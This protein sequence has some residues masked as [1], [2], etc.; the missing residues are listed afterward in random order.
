MAGM[1]WRVETGVSPEAAY[2]Y[3]ADVSHHPDWAMDPMTVDVLEDGKRYRCAAPFFGRP[4]PSTVTVT[5]SQR[6]SR[7]AF[8][9]EDRQGISHHEFRFTPTAGGTL[10]TREMTGV[11]QP[12]YGPILAMLFRG[13]IDKNFNGA[14]AKL[15]QN[16]ESKTAA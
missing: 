3:V 12:W 8:D 15:K 4:N 6:P 16:L 7:F 2:D 11:K 14:L 5:D 13:Q 1:A 10:I 9:A